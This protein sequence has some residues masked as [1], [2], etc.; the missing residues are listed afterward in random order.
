VTD[1]GRYDPR[2]VAAGGSEGVG[3]EFAYLLRSNRH[4]PGADRA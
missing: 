4:Q 3:A 1:L 2:T